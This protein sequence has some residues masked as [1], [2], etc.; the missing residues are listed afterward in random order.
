AILAHQQV[1]YRH[2]VC[3]PG[4]AEDD[5]SGG[6]LA[7]G[8]STP[9]PSTGEAHAIRVLQRL[10]MLLLPSVDRGRLAHQTSPHYVRSRTTC[11]DTPEPPSDF[12]KTGKRVGQSRGFKLLVRPGAIKTS[13]TPSVNIDFRRSV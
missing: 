3:L 2:A 6:E 10:Q 4:T 9:P 7:R 1:A 12:V 13:P 11:A 8:D 5:L